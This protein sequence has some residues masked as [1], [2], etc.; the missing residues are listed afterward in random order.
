MQE[1]NSPHRTA[2]RSLRH[3]LTLLLERDCHIELPLEGD[4]LEGDRNV[5]QF[6]KAAG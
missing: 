4:H 1:A 2:R 6:D 5:G 3:Y